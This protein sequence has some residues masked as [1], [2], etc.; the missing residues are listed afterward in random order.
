M[1]TIEIYTQS[2][3]KV[4]VIRGLLLES[5]DLTI[6]DMKGRKVLTNS[7]ERDS[8]LNKVNVDNVASGVYIIQLENKNYRSSQKVIIN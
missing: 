6:Y 2:N 8:N 7:L 3:P 5:T 4:V 1:D